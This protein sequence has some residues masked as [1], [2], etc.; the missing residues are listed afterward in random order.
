MNSDFHFASSLAAR[1]YRNACR[2]IVLVIAVSD[3]V[4]SGILSRYSYLLKWSTPQLQLYFMIDV[5]IWM[6]RKTL[7]HRQEFPYSVR[8]RDQKYYLE[9]KCLLALS[10]CHSSRRKNIWSVVRSQMKPMSHKLAGKLRRKNIRALIALFSDVRCA[11]VNA[12][13]LES[14]NLM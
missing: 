3:F 8:C 1:I 7:N 5:G 13:S 11:S 2:H 9:I 6:S 14:S 10:T 12:L 4:C